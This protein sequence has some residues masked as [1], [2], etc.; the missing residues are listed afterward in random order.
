[1][2]PSGW[3]DYFPAHFLQFIEVISLLIDSE[4]VFLLFSDDILKDEV[5]RLVVEMNEY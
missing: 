4:F 2:S 1:M 3:L 5:M